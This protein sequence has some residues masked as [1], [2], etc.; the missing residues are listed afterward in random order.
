VRVWLLIAGFYRRAEQYED[1]KV[2]IEAASELVEGLE[3]DVLRDES[4][5][6]LVDAREWGVGKS[7][8]ELWADVCAEVSLN[9]DSNKT[10]C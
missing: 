2:S 5:Q 8:E 1:A 9:P 6:L 3:E 4:G 7:V 10:P